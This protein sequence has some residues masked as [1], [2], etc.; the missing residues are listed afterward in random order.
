VVSNPKPAKSTLTIMVAGIIIWSM[1]VPVAAS[2]DKFTSADG[3]ERKTATP[4]QSPIKIGF[5]T[6]LSGAGSSD[7]PAMVR[8]IKLYLEQ[9]N[10]KMAG[11]SVELDVEDDHGNITVALLKARKLLAKDKVDILAGLI[12]SPFAYAVAP[13]ADESHIPFLVST[14]SADDMTQRKRHKWVLRICS[15]SSQISQPLGEY[16][17][18]NLHLKKVVTIGCN[19]AHCWGVVGGFHKSFE[20]NGGEIIQKIWVPLDGDDYSEQLAHLR[21]DADA[22]FLALVDKSSRLLPA[23]LHKLRPKCSILAST[24]TLDEGVLQQIGPYVEGAISSNSYSETLPNDANKRF[25]AAYRRRYA[26][27]PSIYA[28]RSYMAG[29]WINK[30]ADKLKGNLTDKEKFLTALKQVDLKDGITG[31]LKLDAFQSAIE[32][33]Y[34][35]KVVKVGD[36]YDYSIIYKYPMVSQFWKSKPE[37]FLRHPVFSKSYP[38]CSHCLDAANR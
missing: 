3:P 10:Y 15:T 27:A 17:A 6:S 23:E 12:F 4:K 16:A 20:D 11:R 1:T 7:G 21:P 31:P 2:G 35:R 5:I 18:K 37:D 38:P 13:M 36:R 22:I 33:V 32:N 29:L 24:A 28:V 34:I 8:G 30:A 9:N 14:S 19:Y 26:E 25:V